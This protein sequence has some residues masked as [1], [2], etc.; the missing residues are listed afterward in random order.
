MAAHRLIVGQGA[1]LLQASI[2]GAG[3]SPLQAGSTGAG[4]PACAAKLLIRPNQLP[5]IDCRMSIHDSRIQP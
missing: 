3:A 5:H 1:S 2:T 4:L